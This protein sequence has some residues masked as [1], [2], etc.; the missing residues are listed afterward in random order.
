MAKF[1]VEVLEEDPKWIKLVEN[2][3]RK[4]A[5]PNTCWQNVYRG[6][7]SSCSEI[8]AD[9]EKQTRLAWLLCDCF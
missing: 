3:R 2:E 6:L 8:V 5:G 4:L 9:N 7:F 1:S